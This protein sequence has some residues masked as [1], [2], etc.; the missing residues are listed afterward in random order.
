MRL[1]DLAPR[2]A[3][4]SIAA[5]L[6]VFALNP[7]TALSQYTQTTWTLEQGLPQ[8]AVRVI[9]QTTDGYLWIGTHEGL[10][11][12]DGFEFLSF[13]TENR[14]LPS[15]Y[16]TSLCASRDGTLWIG[17]RA[18]LTHYAHGKF[19]TLTADQG[20]PSRPVESLM[21]DHNGTLWLTSGGALLSFKDS[22]FYHYPR[23]A[24][25]P[26]E[27]ARV[28]FEDSR[29]QLWVTGVG[30]LMKRRGE[31][32]EPVLGRKDLAG[33]LITVVCEGHQG[34]WLAG[35]HGILLLQGAGGTKRFGA[36]EGLP[37]DLVWAVRED[38]SRDPVGRHQ[39]RIDANGKRQI[40]QAD[41]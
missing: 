27:V 1:E 11:R 41:G 17:T 13:T 9:T 25:A 34:L 32:F 29:H 21:E 38:K 7:R 3:V 22:K 15:N 10:A 28:V 14:S 36:P 24:L 37:A 35:N 40:R 26:L 2:W 39:S 23:E 6:P 19:N 8:D 20:A 31:S 4:L 16:V 12:F 18:G 30:A 5:A 33:E